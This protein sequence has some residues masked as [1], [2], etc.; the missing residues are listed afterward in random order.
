MGFFDKLKDGIKNAA[1]YAKMD[2]F[3]IEQIDAMLCE[4]WEKVKEKKPANIG[5]VSLDKEAE[6]KFTY[7]HQGRQIKVEMEHEFPRLEIEMKSSGAK[8][9]TKIMVNEYVDKDG[10]NMSL[11]NED[12]LRKLVESM[13]SRMES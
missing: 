11:K 9:E 7:Q 5:G 8:F 6:Y 3:L 1:A 13:A 12:A 4:R 10:T 2:D